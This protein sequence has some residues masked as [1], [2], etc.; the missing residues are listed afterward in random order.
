MRFPPRVPCPPEAPRAVRA[1]GQLAAC[2]A[3]VVDAKPPLESLPNPFFSRARTRAHA[4]LDEPPSEFLAINTE[5]DMPI[6]DTPK[7]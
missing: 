1:A 5:R 2:G 6:P 3:A 4:A 7:T